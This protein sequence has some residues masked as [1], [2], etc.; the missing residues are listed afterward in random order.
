M[1][2]NNGPLLEVQIRS[3]PDSPLVFSNQPSHLLF[4]VVP[5]G[6]SKISHLENVL[7][8]YLLTFRALEK[9][10]MVSFLDEV[11]AASI[12]WLVTA[13]SY[14]ELISFETGKLNVF[15]CKQKR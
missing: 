3:D 8:S 4:T 15:Y 11:H 2:E 14:L 5:L 7:V 12:Y 6:L 9:A 13:S 10:F 1:L